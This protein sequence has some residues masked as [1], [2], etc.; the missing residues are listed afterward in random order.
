MTEDESEDGALSR[1]AGTRKKFLKRAQEIILEKNISTLYI[2]SRHERLKHIGSY[3]GLSH[4][5]EKTNK[6]G[7]F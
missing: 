1:Q 3:L 4:L 7:G 6:F 2:F 5:T